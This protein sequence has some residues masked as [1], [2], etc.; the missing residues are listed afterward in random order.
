MRT[1]TR[2]QIDKYLIPRPEIGLL[3]WK[4]R[5]GGSRSFNAT[6]AG[7]SA[8]HIPPR[9]YVQVCVDRVTVH[10]H[11]LIWFCVHGYWPERLDHID[12]DSQHDAISNLRL[13]TQSQNMQ[14]AARRSNNKSGFKG[15][16]RATREGRWRAT[17]KVNGRQI[18]LGYTES[19]DEA[20][21][22]YRD[23]AQKY[24][25]EFARLD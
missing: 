18:H 20:R 1:L 21:Q 24:F 10:R 4:P 8:G 13:C 7:Q 25:G 15:V 16:C 9:G 12:G 2:D 6:L 17:I 11:R 19:I 22:L 14:N 5:T 23:A 3:F